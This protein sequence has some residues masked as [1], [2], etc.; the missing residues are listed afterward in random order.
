M[1]V[2]KLAFA[3]LDYFTE[4]YSQKYGK[5]PSINKYRDKWGMDDVISDLGYDDT[6][7]TLDFFFRT[8]RADHKLNDFYNSYDRL[9]ESRIATEKDKQVRRRLLEE[10]K[11]RM[12]S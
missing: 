7:R 10:T 4:A 1:A 6:I 8:A 2:S 11:R 9:N 3:A 5:K 12:Q